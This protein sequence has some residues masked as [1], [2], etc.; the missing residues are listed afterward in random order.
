MDEAVARWRQGD[1]FRGKTWVTSMADLG[2][3]LTDESLSA[4]G[5][6]DDL[7]ALP[8]EV[9]GVVVLTQ[10]CDVVRRCSERPYVQVAPVQEV[11]TDKAALIEK[12]QF[13]RYARIPAI[14]GLIADLDR[15]TTVEKSILAGWER[16]EGCST[17]AERRAFAQA[18]ARKHVRF[19]F[20]DDL[21][22]AVQPLRERILGKHGRASPEG[23]ALREHLR[24]IR[25]T[26]D[27][28]WDADAVSAFIT[29]V[30]K[31][32]QEAAAVGWDELL[33]RWLS[34]CVPAGSIVAIDGTV[35]TLGQMTAQEYVDSDPLDLGHLSLRDADA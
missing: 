27:P 23:M 2:A 35:M 10:T 16:T 19:A 29:F 26:A 24:E 15:V 21:T 14:A 12:G 34:L 8:T 31:D 13:P 1:V 20:P 33:E 6:E 5:G 18:L 4:E 32:T 9:D 7:V 30:R 17:D 3:P 25:I 28:E 22:E 11:T